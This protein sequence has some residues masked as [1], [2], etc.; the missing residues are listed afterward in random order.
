MSIEEEKNTES[1][2]QTEYCLWMVM[3]SCPD[4]DLRLMELLMH[5]HATLFGALLEYQ[6]G[7]QYQ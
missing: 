2:D 6:T 7:L 5:T 3:T 1:R 4:S